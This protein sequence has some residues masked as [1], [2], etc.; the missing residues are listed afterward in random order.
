MG[1]GRVEPVERAVIAGQLGRA[2]IW[3]GG[4]W[5]ALHADEEETLRPA[6]PGEVALIR[7]SGAELHVIPGRCVPMAR[8]KA[9]LE[10]RTA[11]HRLLNRLLTA[12][13]PDLSAPIRRQAAE[14]AEVGLAESAPAQFTRSRLLGIPMPAGGVDL[15]D[16]AGVIIG[17]PRV[18]ALV[19]DLRRIHP[20]IPAVRKAWRL[21]AA[22]L[23]EADATFELDAVTLA[24]VE[25]GVFADAAQA[26][27]D[28]SREA[29]H[30]IV[31]GHATHRTWQGTLPQPAQV[32]TRLAGRLAAT[33]DHRAPERPLRYAPEHGTEQR[34]PP[35]GGEQSVAD[36][37]LAMIQAG[38]DTTPTAAEDTDQTPEKARG[39]R[40]RR[41]R[42]RGTEGKFVPSLEK[43]SHSAAQA[44]DRQKA[45]IITAQAAGRDRL[46]ERELG[47]LVRRQIDDSPRLA[48]SLS[49]LATEGRSR[50]WLAWALRLDE[51]AIAANSADVVARNGYAETLR[52]LGRLDEALAVYEQTR[53]DVPGN[54]VA[55]NGYAETL[56]ALGRLDEALAVYEQTRRDVPGDVV[57]RGG[58]AVVM[59]ELGYHQAARES[60]DRSDP[61]RTCNDWIDFHIVAMS[62]LREGNLEEATRRLRDGS[63]RCQFM[64]CRSFFQGALG[65]ALIWDQRLAEAEQLLTQTLPAAGA[66]LRAGSA[67]LLAHVLAAQ[68]RKVQADAVLA[69]LSECAVWAIIDTRTVLT[70]RYGLLGQPQTPVSE[71]ARLDEDLRRRELALVMV[72]GARAG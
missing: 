14:T 20:Q 64:S 46:A 49:S 38:R 53:R 1:G 69:R 72:D 19:A 31:L 71:R 58:R 34:V 60:L 43:G 24:M 29:L 56:R 11:G 16:A 45:A 17:L 68:D 55:R 48:K 23:A 8:L 10:A 65:L 2:L 61:P 36:P 5:W 12:L 9:E 15:T 6:K 30:G 35:A 66:V 42:T 28:Q 57:A 22:E 27:T 18:Q 32:L 63:E 39:R 7:D 21:V 51:L 40:A 13:D 54:V 26:L 52:A 25:L 41:R 70:R 4:R 67:L 3:R 59:I 33:I 62:Y 50:G 37:L 44:V 47:D